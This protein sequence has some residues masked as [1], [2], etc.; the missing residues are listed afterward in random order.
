MYADQTLLFAPILFVHLLWPIYLQ[1][2]ESKFC[3]S[4]SV[5]RFVSF[6]VFSVLLDQTMWSN[7]N[8]NLLFFLLLYGTVLGVLLGLVLKDKAQQLSE[9][10]EMKRFIGFPGELFL[11]MM[12]LIVFPFI[13][14]SVITSLTMIDRITSA[15]VGKPAPQAY[16]AP[17][18]RGVEATFPQTF[19]CHPN[20]RNES[21]FIK[22]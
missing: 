10:R 12:M 2:N 16:V 13:A 18:N 6:H 21:F 22:S 7:S 5:V 17:L 15:K 4:R 8:E 19:L 20:F 9:S 1:S 11:R 14:S 3:V